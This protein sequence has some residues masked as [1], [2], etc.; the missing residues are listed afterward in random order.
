MI[1]IFLASCRFGHA[2]YAGT[3]K[4]AGDVKKPPSQRPE[5]QGETLCQVGQPY[6]RTHRS[7]PQ[8]ADYNYRAGGHELRVFMPD[9]SNAEIAAAEKG[10]IEFGLWVDLPELWVISRFFHPTDGK[11]TMS[12]DCTY[13]W[14]R[15]KE[16]ERTAP[17]AWEE[18]NPNLRA[19][20]SIVLV[21]GCNGIIRALRTVS[22]SPEFTRSFHR[23]IAD[24]IALPYDK[25]E[26]EGTV[27]AITGQF[28][29]DQLW[30]KC[31]HRCEGGA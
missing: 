26:H 22:Y 21:E 5:R 7:W 6:D 20:L 16:A 25:A 13:Q 29:T 11:M 24:Q 14:H 1:P 10:R 28:T 30:A 15:V 8:G 4:G 3:K 19:L 27:E 12:F 23:A 31:Q 17:S 2:G 9:L 18:V